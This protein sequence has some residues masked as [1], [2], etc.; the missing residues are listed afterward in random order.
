MKPD[1]LATGRL[2]DHRDRGGPDLFD[3]CRSQC[4][5]LSASSGSAAK[6]L[7]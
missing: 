6:G 3:R 2:F 5:A 4:D 7:Q 1:N